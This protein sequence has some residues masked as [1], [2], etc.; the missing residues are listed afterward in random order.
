M[1][2][3]THDGENVG[4][5]QLERGDP[6]TLSASGVF[7]NLGGSKALAAWIKSIGGEED[8]GVVFAVLND[9][10]TLLDQ[11]GNTVEFAEGHLMAVPEDG[12][13]FLDISG[14][15]EAYYTVH[16]SEHISAMK[17]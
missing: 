3:L 9:T 8:N 15:S 11:A 14:F 12:E 1:Y 17:K 10:F 5:T 16:F 2:L 6:L 4:T 7:N 13:A